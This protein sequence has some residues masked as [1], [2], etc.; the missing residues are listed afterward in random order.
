MY[1][2]DPWN[3][4]KRDEIENFSIRI[5]TARHA[6][7]PKDETR[8]ESDITSQH[9]PLKQR[10]LTAALGTLGAGAFVVA[11]QAAPQ[12]SMTNMSTESLSQM[13]NNPD[14]GKP[15]SPPVKCDRGEF[16]RK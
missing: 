10:L 8:K 4:P 14:Q 7:R 1:K 3:T 11:V 2:G 9:R 6:P 12:A 5:R 15:F 13:A 16:S